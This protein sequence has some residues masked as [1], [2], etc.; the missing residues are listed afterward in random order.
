VSVPRA[1]PTQ[2][3]RV[4]AG[5]ALNGL[6]IPLQHVHRPLPTEASLRRDKPGSD[7][8]VD[9]VV[10]QFTEHHHHGGTWRQGGSFELES[11]QQQGLPQRRLSEEFLRCFDRAPVTRRNACDFP[12]KTST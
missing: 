10:A 1:R 9:Q 4:P 3:R 8:S 6:R 12:D 11:G 7:F 5:G 2:Q